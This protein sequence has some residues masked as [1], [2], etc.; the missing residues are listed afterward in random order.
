MKQICL[1]VN[2]LKEIFVA[3]E[4]QMEM[5][6]NQL[7]DDFGTLKETYGEDS[8]DLIQTTKEID[9]LLKHNYETPSC[10]DDILVK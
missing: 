1:I 6:N 8:P 4:K 9:F 5:L 7:I 2:R 10:L 3:D